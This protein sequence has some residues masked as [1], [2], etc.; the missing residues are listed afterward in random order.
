MKKRLEVFKFLGIQFLAIVL[1][2]S[3]TQ[4]FMW[5]PSENQL[6]EQVIVKEVKEVSSVY[7][8]LEKDLQEIEN[9]TIK[10]KTVAIEEGEVIEYDLIPDIKLDY[11]TTIKNSDLEV[12][13]I[14]VSLYI[15]YMIPFILLGIVI[16]K[17]LYESFYVFLKEKI[18]FEIDK[19][20][21]DLLSA[22]DSGATFLGLLGSL[23]GM[24]LLVG[25]SNSLDLLKENLGLVFQTTLLGTII[26]YIIA[27]L[28]PYFN[29]RLKYETR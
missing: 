28:H 21:L 16:N 13:V 25:D 7:E 29:Q 17:S 24:I 4:T 12:S 26:S 23:I 22:C 18:S 15:T 6:N 5:V 19:F 14:Y 11:I 2:I 9:P 10:K 27:K 1:W 3:I 8:Q 20:I